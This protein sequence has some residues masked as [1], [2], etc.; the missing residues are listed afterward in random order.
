MKIIMAD[1]AGFCFG[2]KRAMD[3]VNNEINN[4]DGK[5]YSYGPLIHNPQVVDSLE[6]KGLKAIKDLSKINEG[7]IIIRSHGIPKYEEDKMIDLKLSIVDCTCPYVKAVHKRVENYMNKGYN[8]VIIGN[9]KHPE[10]IGIN[11]W[12]NNK[13]LIVENIK[14]VEQLP[15]MDKVCVVAQTTITKE[16]FD[17]ISKEI[18]AKA[19]IVE[20]FNTIC[21]ATKERQESAATVAKISDA[22]VV[23][24]GYKSS[25]TLKLVEISKKYCKNVFHIETIKDLP[26][27]E[28]LKFNTIGITAGASTPDWI[29]KEAIETM[30]NLNNNEMMEAIE[31]S[32]TQIRRGDVIKGKVIFTT[33]NEIMVN[34]NYKSDGIITKDEL[35]NDPDVNPKELYKEGDEIEVYVVKIDDGEGN[36][37]LSTKR[38]EEIKNWELLEDVF[39]NEG[40]VQA[41]VLRVVKG[42]LIALT[43]G[44]NAFIPASHASVNYTSDLNTFKGEILDVKILDLDKQK[45]RLVLSR[46]KVEVEELRATQEKVWNSLEIGSTI[47]GIVQR[48]TNFGA[49]VDLGGVDGLIHISDLSWNKI[50]HPS[51]VVN[52][53]DKVEVEILDFNRDKNRISLGLKQMT[54]EPWK[55]FEGNIEI[56]NVIQ[57]TVVNLLDFGAFIRL[58][59]GVDGLLHVS[60]ISKEHIDK[61][62]SILNIGDR[63]TVKVIDI[64]K[65]ERKISLSMKDVQNDKLDKKDS[66]EEIIEKDEEDVT[67]G[68]LINNHQ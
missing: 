18:K 40:T 2:V 17:T 27:Q 12:C 53:G 54:E 57:G 9:S 10:V 59:E 64:N 19:S 63:V 52:P 33:N 11:G 26:L 51:Q 30:D 66:S 25:N 45:R 8:I 32:F 47:E 42:G 28:V 21:K 24:G 49:F 3:I 16:K 65:E 39:E 50:K 31:S 67:I 4:I 35:S 15:F 14:S 55:V 56:G 58:D 37:V 43:K 60:Q 29:I 20:I 46:K 7:K 41:K 1:N 62:S 5:L 36:V 22:M 44:I 61:P 23:I 48:L 13:A 6:Q 68:D 38:L 34:I